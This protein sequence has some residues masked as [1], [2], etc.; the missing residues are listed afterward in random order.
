MRRRSCGAPR[1]SL[2]VFF[3]ARVRCREG[4]VAV[5]IV[6]RRS[7][8][9]SSGG[10]HAQHTVPPPTLHVKD[11]AQDAAEDV[12]EG[13]LGA[14]KDGSLTVFFVARAI[15]QRREA[16]KHTSLAVFFVA[17][18]IFQRRETPKHTRAAPHAALGRHVKD[19]H[20]KER[21]TCGAPRRTGA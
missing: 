4:R 21:R 1:G 12:A 19:E 18:V 6:Q 13:V 10:T 14:E 2:T 5:L 15:F 20:V 16:P 3:V 11:V 8:A 17:R 7:S 9:S